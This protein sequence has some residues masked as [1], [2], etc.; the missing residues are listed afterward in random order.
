MVQQNLVSYILAQMRQGKSLEDINKFLLDSGYDK[1]DVESSIQYVINTQTNPQ[2]AEQQRIQQLVAYVQQQLQAGYNSQTI[3]NFLI[4]RGYPYYEVNAAL[5]QATAPQKAM[6]TE[7]KLFL[8]AVI[9][10]LAV[11]SAM[12]F[13]YLQAYVHV[14]GEM[15]EQLLDVE[16]EKLSTLVEQ[17]G[18]L[19]YQVNL[20][21]FGSGQRYDVLMTYKVI[22]RETEEV[23]LEEMET[24]A[25][26]TTVEKLKRFDI[27]QDTKPG[28]YLLRVD[29]S[30]E[31]FTATSGF[32]FNIV[33]AQEAEELRED[34]P[35]V[36]EE[37]ITEEMLPEIPKPEEIV[38]EI[39]EVPEEAVPTPIT[40]APGE[41]FYKGKTR[42]QALEMVKA[43]SV[44]DPERAVSMCQEFTLSPNRQVCLRTIAE[45][46]E[47]PIFC[48]Y[49]EDA[50]D[51]DNCYLQLAMTTALPG[52][53]DKIQ[54]ASVKQSCELLI[55]ASESMMTGQPIDG[56]GF[57]EKLEPFGVTTAPV[58]T[59]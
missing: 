49:I 58:T 40:P 23:V 20:M 6:K 59:P 30:Y 43:V 27:P 10:M 14:G 13:F 38:P 28:K 36:P 45:F 34:V 33:S 29:A 32:V 16:T 8:F 21:S 37:N 47:S 19:T 7:H 9:A 52:S 50:T 31:D 41:K 22:D 39:P 25:L 51:R 26:S 1:A 2:L 54:D 56:G 24:V 48:E 55:L 53:C 11:T 5:Q 12:V 15:P 44:R 42:Q 35:E 57:R 18:E 17:G 3:A 4:S 46:K